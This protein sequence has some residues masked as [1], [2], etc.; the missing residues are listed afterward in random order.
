[1]V[2][3]LNMCP[4]WEVLPLSTCLTERFSR[5]ISPSA[6]SQPVAPS[7]AHSKPFGVPLELTATASC[8]CS[9]TSTI[10]RAVG[11]KS[12]AH[13]PEPWLVVATAKALLATCCAT[14]RMPVAHCQG[15]VVVEGGTICPSG[16]S[17]QFRVAASCLLGCDSRRIPQ[18]VWDVGH[19]RHT[20]QVQSRGIICV[21]QITAAA[22]PPQ[23]F[24]ASTPRS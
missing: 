20:S 22:C 24:P 19:I 8:R 13:S 18:G 1:M 4:K 9:S 6:S 17:G 2:H 7:S 21:Q 14:R 3:T 5:L 16:G 11:C 10:D 12:I 23:P 15:R